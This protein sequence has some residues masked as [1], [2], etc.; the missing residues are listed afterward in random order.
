[1]AG[2]LAKAKA[3]TLTDGEAR[4]V[5]EWR[6]AS[7]ENER[8]FVAFMD[9]E[10][11]RADYLLWRQVDRARGL[12]TMRKR[13]AA[14]RRTR[15]TRTWQAVAAAMAALMVA[16]GGWLLARK[17]ATQPVPVARVTQVE[18]RK[19]TLRMEG[20]AVVVVDS[21]SRMNTAGAVISRDSSGRLVYTNDRRKTERAAT[22]TLEIPRGGEFFLTLEDGTQ[23]WLNADT[24]LSYPSVFGTNERRVRLEGE[25]YFDVRHEA[26]RPF[27]VEIGS[28]IIEVLGTEFNANA[29][30]GERTYTTLVEGRVRVSTKGGES[31]TLRPGEQLI[32][33][34]EEW[35][36]RTV[37]AE[38]VAS[39]RKGM[40]VL[41]N[42]TLEEIMAQ[43]ERWYNFSVFYRNEG[44]K[45]IVF[46]G[47]IPRYTSFEDILRVLEKT[48]DIRFEVR[49]DTVTVHD[50]K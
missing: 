50:N 47:K 41:E 16:A 19:P 49:G 30:R 39:W 17:E 34:G 10:R 42:R 27:R 11:L 9:D 4:E 43:L 12:G 32:D 13:T 5:A 14:W 46:R 40:L 1:M 31:V 37:D 26:A 15:R 23:V 45:H 29:H 48:G 7:P 2:L 21:I 18:T 6:S 25:A 28:R 38:E 22:H 20:A 3:G 33:D 44:L 8:T 35:S 24:K 36:V